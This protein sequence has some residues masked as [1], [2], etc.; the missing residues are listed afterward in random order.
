[1]VEATSTAVF[2]IGHAG[3]IKG[4]AAFDT[5]LES[6]MNAQDFLF[7]FGQL[8]FE[9]ADLGLHRLQ[10]ECETISPDTERLLRARAA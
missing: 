9:P 3:A 7:Q 5:W 2:F 8:F 6:F 10:D 1:L 4:A